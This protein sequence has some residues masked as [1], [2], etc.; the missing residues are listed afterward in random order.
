MNNEKLADVVHDTA[1][2]VHEPAMV[3]K[4]WGHEEIF[5]NDSYCMKTIHLVP[6]SRTSMHFHV[7]KHETILVMEGTLTLGYKDSDGKPLKCLVY[8]GHALV[9]PPG[10]M[11]QLEATDERVVLVEASTHDDSHD[12]VRVA[13]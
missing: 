13:M 3:N 12:S 11:H 7:K 6:N 2:L 8:P 1:R 4:R 9:I 5:I 10:F